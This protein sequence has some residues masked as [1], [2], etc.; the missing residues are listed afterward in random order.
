ME[1]RLITISFYS[2]SSDETFRRLSRQ[3]TERSIDLI[4][5]V[6]FIGD[7]THRDLHSVVRRQRQM[8]I[9]DL[10]TAYQRKSLTEK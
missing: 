7:R 10:Y 4:S 6:F 1:G 8:C 9:I 3:Y 2:G 5:Q